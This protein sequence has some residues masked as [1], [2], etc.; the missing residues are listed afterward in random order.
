MELFIFNILNYKSNRGKYI[1]KYL[2]L[3]KNQK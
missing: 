1:K 2:K 3:K